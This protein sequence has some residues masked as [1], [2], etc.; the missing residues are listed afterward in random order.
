MSS[1][2]RF[3]VPSTRAG[4]K[5]KIFDII[6]QLL[7]VS[8]S[9]TLIWG[10]KAQGVHEQD[11]L[12]WVE[13]VLKSLPPA[14]TL[15]PEAMVSMVGKI[16]KRSNEYEVRIV[17]HVDVS[18]EAPTPII[19]ERADGTSQPIEQ[20]KVKGLRRLPRQT[21]FEFGGNTAL[22]LPTTN[23]MIVNF[24]PDPPQDPHAPVEPGMSFE[25]LT[26]GKIIE[27]DTPYCPV[28]EDP[29]IFHKA[30]TRPTITHTPA[31]SK[32]SAVQTEAVRPSEDQ[33]FRFNAPANTSISSGR[34]S[35]IPPPSP[36]SRKPRKEK[37]AKNTTTNASIGSIPFPTMGPSN[38]TPP[39]Q[40]PTTSLIRNTV[41]RPSTAKKPLRQSARETRSR[42]SNASA[43]SS[44]LVA[45]PSARGTTRS[46]SI[47]K[48]RKR[49]REEEAEEEATRPS[50]RLRSDSA[51]SDSRLSHKVSGMKDAVLKF[52]AGVFK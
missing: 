8:L 52:A 32:L 33:V 2:T 43:S 5:H 39:S 29:P 35:N 37:K 20:V 3:G 11:F 31:P 17:E 38:I 6:Q 1:N 18:K 22:F 13:D 41:P 44:K 34:P 51:K 50:R 26:S 49:A 7:A 19:M 46:V 14:E 40:P 16:L 42:K 30:S 4:H 47:K 15:I 27:R 23:P 12:D 36:T 21:K 10:D 48:G 9:Y 28:E 24:T 25:V 45:S